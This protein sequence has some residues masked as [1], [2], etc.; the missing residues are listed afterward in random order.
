MKKTVLLAACVVL[1]TLSLSA[2]GSGAK[3]EK[4]IVADLQTHESFLSPEVKITDWE[5]IKRQTDTSAHSDLVYITVYTDD[6]GLT[7]ALSYIMR[8]ELYND[9]WVLESVEDYR[10]G[11][12]TMEGLTE[13]QIWSDIQTGDAF[14]LEQGNLLT[15][16]L[17]IISES[18]PNSSG[19]VYNKTIEV[20]LYGSDLWVDYSASYS[21]TYAVRDGKWICDYVT[22][23]MS[24]YFPKFT[25]SVEAT[26]KVMDTLGYDSF[27][28]VETQENFVERMA[29][30][31][32]TAQRVYPL[33]TETY[34]VSI[35][36]KFSLEHDEDSTDW[37]YN[38]DSI[39]HTLQNVDWN[40][41]GT[42]R[43]SGDDHSSRA[44][45]IELEITDIVPTD[46]P[47]VYTATVRSDS[48]CRHIAFIET[49]RYYC[50]T[51]GYVEA[52]L[53]RE[54][55]NWFNDT[56]GIYQLVV[57]GI[58]A[59]LGAGMQDK[60]DGT[61]QFDLNR[62]DVSGVQW[63]NVGLSNYLERS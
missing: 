21:M 63:L 50:V 37:T 38:S 15:H 26:D 41:A 2:C 8:Y 52:T 35:P 14:L 60:T 33:G 24:G 20:D 56:D 59:S 57:P 13:E 11:P 39:E 49:R 28:Y 34:Q 6:P 7:C 61:F 53:K 54:R 5:I 3:S 51:D 58:K 29:T 10:E 40:I 30:A 9:G 1:L 32:Y 44:W 47:E 19:I 23:A 27:E 22:T 31:V 48:V 25:P 55:S 17:E 16:K 42:W 12:W 62:T 46:D 43:S 4:Q 18:Y 36:L 45:D